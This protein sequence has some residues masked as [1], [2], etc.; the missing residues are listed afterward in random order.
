[1][2][3]PHLIDDRI[4]PAGEDGAIPPQE[5]RQTPSAVPTDLAEDYAAEKP[6]EDVLAALEAEL[7]GGQPVGRP[8]FR[9][10]VPLRPRVELLFDPNITDEQRNAWARK[11]TRKVPDRAVQGGFRQELDPFVMALHALAATNAGLYVNGNL[12]TDQGRPL[13]VADVSIREWLGAGDLATEAIRRIFGGDAHAGD[14]DVEAA[15]RTLQTRAGY[16][17]GLLEPSTEDPSTT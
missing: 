14:A 8:P 3:D 15:F 9:V 16:D 5:R 2:T 10:Q 11:A 4:P 13:T 12:A 6:E 1:M 17:N 7:G